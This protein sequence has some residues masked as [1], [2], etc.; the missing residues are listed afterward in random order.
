VKNALVLHAGYSGGTELV[1]T[2]EGLAAF[3]PQK[4]A[5]PACINPAMG[6]PRDLPYHPAS[7]TSPRGRRGSMASGPLA[8][9][10]SWISQSSQAARL[11]ASPTS[12][13]KWSRL[14]RPAPWRL[15]G[16]S[17]PAS[18]GVPVA[19]PQEAVRG[20]GPDRPRLPG[21]DPRTCAAAMSRNITR[22]M[23]KRL[24]V[25]YETLTRFR[26]DLVR[27]QHRLRPTGPWARTAPYDIVA[28]AASGLLHQGYLRT[29]RRSAGPPPAA[30]PPG[31]PSPGVCAAL[32]HRER[33]GGARW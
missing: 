26:P 2:L 31:T 8:G 21:R 1:P 20:A 23:A 3:L 6:R 25:D 10:A 19:E 15:T 4:R 29:A 22:S 32:F 11:H 12:A 9:S 30:S 14:N 5:A 16:S 33:T 18:Q 24:G 13:R 27:G 7:A 17:C 28:Q